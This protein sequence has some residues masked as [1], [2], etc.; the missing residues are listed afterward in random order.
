MIWMFVSQKPYVENLTHKV[1]VLGCRAFGRLWGHESGT[2]LD[3]IS[4]FIKD[5]SESFCL[6]RVKTQYDITVYEPKSEPSPDT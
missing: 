4:A 2:P 3:G 1:M 5:T 6:L